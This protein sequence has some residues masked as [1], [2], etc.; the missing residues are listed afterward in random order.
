MSM[1]HPHYPVDIGFLTRVKNRLW[2]QLVNTVIG[3]C[4]HARAVIRFDIATKTMLFQVIDQF[5]QIRMHGAIRLEL[6][7]ECRDGRMVN[8]QLQ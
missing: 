3:G 2:R 6:L 5:L 1:H 7:Q 8:P 4:D